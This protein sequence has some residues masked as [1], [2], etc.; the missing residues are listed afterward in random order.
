MKVP[1]AGIELSE[2]D[3]AMEEPRKTVRVCVCFVV[4][5]ELA[6]FWSIVSGV[7]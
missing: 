6:G 1:R 2:L 4:L 5:F 7:V 3:D